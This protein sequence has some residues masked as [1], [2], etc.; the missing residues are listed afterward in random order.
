M[1]GG[2][3]SGSGVLTRLGAGGISFVHLTSP[4]STACGCSEVVSPMS[5]PDRM[6]LRAEEGAALLARLSVY[7][8][9]RSDCEILS[10]VLRLDMWRMLT[11]AEAKV[12]IRQRRTRLFGAR[13]TATE[14]PASEAS[15]PSSEALGEGEGGGEWALCEEDA[16]GP[17]AIESAS[18]A[19]GGHRAGTGRLGAVASSG[20][21]RIECRHEELSVGQRCPVCGQGHR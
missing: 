17:A 9:S 3:A 21:T 14:A 12:S 20:A 7:A 4:L 8:P 10:Q 18:K 16:V 1:R 11:V 6:P 15:T 13:R 5:R 2:A 19:K